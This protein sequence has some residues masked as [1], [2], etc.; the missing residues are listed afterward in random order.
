MKKPMFALLLSSTVLLIA[1]STSNALSPFK[2]AFDAK[3]VK[4]S[5]SDE[6]KSL[7]KKSSCNTCHVKGEKKDWLNAYGLSLAKQIQGNAKQRLA[8]AKAAGTDA[9]AT[10]NKKLLNELEHAF[11]KT[12]AV[13]SPSGELFI[14]MLKEHKLP[15]A[16]GAKSVKAPAAEDSDEKTQAHKGKS[17]PATT[18]YLMRGIVKGNCTSLGKLLKDGPAD[19]EAWD[20][21]ACHAACLN[22]MSFVLMDDGRCPDGVWAK[23]ATDSLRKGTVAVMAAIKARDAAAANT[24]FKTVTSSCAACHK[25]HKK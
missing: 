24:A 19:D 25:A 6:F 23:A 22:E 11:T 16:D 8:T 15:T 2:K 12:E 13:K 7:F 10:E 17:R 4:S 14:A 21:A 3:Y 9:L 1:T 5:D 18:K 20:A